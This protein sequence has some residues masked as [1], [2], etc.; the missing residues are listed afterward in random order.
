MRTIK[1]LHIGIS[2]N[3]GFFGGVEKF[4][5]DYY[6]H[7]DHSKFLFDF[8]LCRENSLISV[9]DKDYMKDSSIKVLHVLKEK[10]NSLR[11]F[12]RLYKVVLFELKKTDYD[13]VHVDTS[14]APVQIAC[15]YAAKRSG[16]KIRIAHSHSSGRDSSG[17]YIKRLIKDFAY[18]LSKSFV[19]FLASDYFACSIQAGITLFGNKG[20]HSKRFRIIKNAIE[21]EKYRYNINQ[22]CQIREENGVTED[23]IIFGSVGRLD[24][25]KCIL[26][27]IDV[28]EVFHRRNR[29][30]ELW[31]VGDGQQKDE[32]EDAVKKYNL[33][34]S[35]KMFGQRSDVANLMQGM[36]VLL[37]PSKHEGLGISAI[38]AQ[39]C[40]LPVFASDNIPKETAITSLIKYHSREEGV[41]NWANEIDQFINGYKR[42]DTYPEIVKFGYDINLAAKNLE[43]IYENRIAE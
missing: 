8:F 27:T 4:M 19:R 33:A 30:S 3:S 36:D 32:I 28:F 1:V 22:R 41:D 39:A 5:T 18:M 2:S 26:F 16:I 40:G 23:A 14:F 13:I 17:N 21:A 35:I 6:S 42:Y 31:I 29:N 9:A 12:Y 37:F 34:D 24:P 7:M 43:M 20:I 11:H 10:D 15:L 25:L 38:E